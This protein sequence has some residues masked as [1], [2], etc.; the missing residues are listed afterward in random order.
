MFGH[1]DPVLSH[2]GSKHY[3]NFNLADT[4]SSYLAINVERFNCVDLYKFADVFSVDSVREHCV[5]SIHC[6]FAKVAFSEQFCSLSVDQLTE[7]ISHDELDVKEETTVWEA[8]VRWVQ[9]SRE[10]RLHHLPSILPHIR[11]NLLTSD[12]T[13]AILDHPLVRED[14]GSSEVI[15]N[16]VQQGNP[17]LKSRLGPNS[18]NMDMALLCTSTYEKHEILF[19]NPWPQ[20]RKYISCSYPDADIGDVMAMTV[21]SDNN[22]FILSYMYEKRRGQLYLIQYNH[23]ENAWEPALGLS[24]GLV[25]QQ[26]PGDWTCNEEM[27][28]E[29][30]GT[31]YHL[32]SYTNFIMMSRYDQYSDKWQEC[33]QLTLTEVYRHTYT[34]SSGPNLY[35]LTNTE[36]HRYDPG[37]DCWSKRTPNFLP[38][39]CTAVAMGTE[40]FC[41]DSFFT[42][43]MVYDTES[44]C[45][46]RLQGWT[47]PGNLLVD[48]YTVSHQ[49]GLFV[50][51]NQLHILVAAYDPDEEESIDPE[52]TDPPSPSESFVYVYDR[53]AD[54]W[55]DL[56]VNLPKA[57]YGIANHVCLVARLN[58]KK[59]QSP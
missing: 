29:A 47:T 41:T 44:D 59:L 7:I 37:Q 58:T 48:D 9:H 32:T 33:S 55:R 3:S 26:K 16:V 42:H 8:V 25:P 12:N 17:D 30:D 40:I 24:N 27:L 53:S 46:Q 23:A 45:W 57:Y 11:F 34:L 50:L 2:V 5:Q 43:T 14:P 39:I 31:L 10:D 20:Q 19:L 1:P 21:T 49:P 13:A 28:S 6:H 18:T 15:R 54:T 35:F 51:E 38:D 52:S 22:I 56:E 4:C 36:L